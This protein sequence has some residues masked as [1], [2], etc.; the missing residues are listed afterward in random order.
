MANI[1][2]RKEHPLKSEIK[3]KRGLTIRWVSKQVGKSEQH[4]N[5][6]LNGR[7][8]FPVELLKQVC[9]LLDLP[10]EP[11]LKHTALHK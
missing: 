8:K 11:Y 6:C 2:D 5:N 1:T 7:I 3:V 9:Q 4:L 10:P